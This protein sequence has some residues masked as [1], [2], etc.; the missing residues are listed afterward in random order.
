MLANLLD[1]KATGNGGWIHVRFVKMLQ[2]IIQFY[3]NELNYLL[4]K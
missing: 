3:F 2:K 4:G 1:A